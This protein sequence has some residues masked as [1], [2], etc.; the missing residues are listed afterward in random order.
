[1]PHLTGFEPGQHHK[2]AND[3]SSELKSP[4]K[5]SG[6]ESFGL[7]NL[8]SYSAISSGLAAQWNRG[9]V[10]YHAVQDQIPSNDVC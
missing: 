2:G 9:S 4:I 6:E 10:S 8:E 1:M 5:L 3:N 7:Y